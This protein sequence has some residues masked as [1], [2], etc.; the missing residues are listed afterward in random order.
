LTAR[1]IEHRTAISGGHWLLCV[2][3]DRIEDARAELAEYAAENRRA[4]LTAV[5]AHGDGWAGVLAYAALL[6][7]VATLAESGAF[8][9][10]WGAAGSLVSSRAL[11]GEWWRFVTALTLHVD[12][13]HLLGNAAFGAFF[14][15]FVGRYLGDGAGWMLILLSGTAGNALNALVQP[16]GHRAIGAS[17]AVFGALGILA[18]FSWRKGLGLASWRKGWTPI[19]AAVALLAYTGTAGEHT[20]VIAHL[21]GFLSGIVLGL[22]PAFGTSRGSRLQAMLGLLALLIVAAAW[23]LA[24]A[25]DRA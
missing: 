14:G 20:D 17:T 5:S 1:E 19:A 7:G 12:L 24:L 4:T 23:A 6:L 18:A 13:A 22:L 11:S 3:A 15:Y 16:P 21:T 8:G 9:F 25:G 10:D 2:P